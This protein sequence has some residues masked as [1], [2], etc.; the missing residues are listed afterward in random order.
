L[1]LASINQN[2]TGKTAWVF[3]AGMTAR[4]D[5]KKTPK[6]ERHYIFAIFSWHGFSLIESLFPKPLK[7]HSIHE[8]GH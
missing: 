8:A 1:L 2:Q 7:L 4:A 6:Q 3:H 5:V